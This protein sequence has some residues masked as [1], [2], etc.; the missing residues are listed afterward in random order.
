[1][2][3]AAVERKLLIIGE[4]VNQI[5]RIEPAL[6]SDISQTRQRVGFRYVLAHGY[7]AVED[8]TVWGIANDDAPVPAKEA[9]RLLKEMN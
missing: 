4:V 2:L 1:M 5:L 7:F 9:A 3:R 6:E 8:E